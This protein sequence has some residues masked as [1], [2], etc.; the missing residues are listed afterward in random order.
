MTDPSR[1][2]EQAVRRHLERAEYRF[3][4]AIADLLREPRPE[5]PE[6][7]HRREAV[8]ASAALGRAVG[9]AGRTIASLCKAFAD[10][11]STVIKEGTKER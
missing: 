7:R 4:V 1:Q 6:E 3:D 5:S 2:L 11:F 8:A 10:A 9:E